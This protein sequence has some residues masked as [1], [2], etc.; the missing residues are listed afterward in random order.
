MKRLSKFSRFEDRVYLLLALLAAFGFPF[1]AIYIADEII[2][3][4]LPSLI[5]Y[6]L[7]A[8]CWLIG[9]AIGIA[10]ASSVEDA[11]TKI[12]KVFGKKPLTKVLSEIEEERELRVLDFEERN[13][14]NL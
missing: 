9:F 8:A 6:P 3:K 11:F 10:L 5:R 12:R 2:L 1:V 13:E 14:N 4:E 7:W